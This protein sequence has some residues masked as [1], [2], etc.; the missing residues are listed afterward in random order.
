[1]SEALL[2]I[3]ALRKSFGG[4]AVS[5]DITLDVHAGEI[6]ALIGPN[7]AGKTTL[8]DQIGGQLR[9]DGGRIILEGRDITTWPVHARARAGLARSFQITR[10]MDDMSVFDNALLAVM[11]HAGTPWR[12]LGAAREDEHLRDAA[13]AVLALV[14]M[15]AHAGQR[16]GELSHGLRRQLE[17][18]LAL[19]GRPLLLLLDEPMAGLGPRES[20]RMVEILREVAEG[21]TL[22]LVEHDMDAVFALA[23]R[24]SVLVGGRIIASGA[25]ADIRRDAAVRAAYLGEEEE[26]DDA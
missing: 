26:R 3:E 21:R 11:A 9:P 12:F 2:R 25:P 22:L 4:L 7:G 8:M 23:S 6:H 20:A 17:L 15:G 19:A 24:I 5:R 16:A 18:A 10:L 1:M 14:D 13:I